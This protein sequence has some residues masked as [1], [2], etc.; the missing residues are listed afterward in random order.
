MVV[1]YTVSFALYRLT[2]VIVCVCCVWVVYVCFVCVC[3]MCMCVVCMCFVCV[4]VC[5]I[6]LFLINASELIKCLHLHVNC[7]QDVADSIAKIVSLIDAIGLT[8]EFLL[9]ISH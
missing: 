1:N 9:T 7:S 2:I 6:F 8:Q 5:V 4:Y 3:C